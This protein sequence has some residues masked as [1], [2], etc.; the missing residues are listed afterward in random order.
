[1]DNFTPLKAIKSRLQTWHNGVFALDVIAAILVSPSVS[2]VF[3]IWVPRDRVKF[4]TDQWVV[5]ST[6]LVFFSRSKLGHKITFLQILT[7]VHYSIT[8]KRDSLNKKIVLEN[9][10]YSPIYL[11][12]FSESGFERPKE[13]LSKGPRYKDFKSDTSAKILPNEFNHGAREGWHV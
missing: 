10:H 12:S 9:S 3:V 13:L 11:P 4:L 6:C 2:M 5:K 1:M 8:V 7:Y